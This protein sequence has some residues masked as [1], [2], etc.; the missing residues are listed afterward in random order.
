[1]VEKHNQFD[2]PR[3][4]LSYGF[5]DDESVDFYDTFGKMNQTGRP[6]DY[7]RNLT[8]TIFRNDLDKIA[9]QRQKAVNWLYEHYG[10][11]VDIPSADVDWLTTITQPNGDEFYAANVYPDLH[12]Y[13]G[14]CFQG[15][16]FDNAQDTVAWHDLI[17]TYEVKSDDLM[18]YGKFGGVEGWK[19]QVG[20][21]ILIGMYSV[22]GLP[23]DNIFIDYY[24]TCPLRFNDY[25]NTTVRTRGQTMVNCE[26]ESGVLG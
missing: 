2:P 11:V 16:C 17:W 3:I 13:P 18:Y 24:A 19:A 22:E 25:F 1:M 10:I 14:V 23:L 9:A 20:D 8:E 7:Y 15:T 4:L 21:S 26:V 5:W 12:K 6:V